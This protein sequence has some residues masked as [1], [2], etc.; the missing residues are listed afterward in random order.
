M[1]LEDKI[2]KIALENAVEHNG[3]AIAH[4][5]LGRVLATEPSMRS[6]IP[7]LHAMIDEIVD[8]VNLLEPDAQRAELEKLGGPE[9]KKR[10]ETKGLPP[11]KNAEKGVV[12]RFAPNPDGAIHLGNARPALLSYAYAQKYNGKF[13][14]RFEDT[15]PKVKTPEKRFYDWIRE[16]VKWLGIKWNTEAIQS[17]RLRIYYDYAERL[18]KMGGAYICTCPVETWR[19]LVKKNWPCSCRSLSLDTQLERWQ[20]MLKYKFKAGQA[21]MRIKTDLAHPNP[22]IRDWPAMRIVDKPVHPLVHKMHVW[23]LYNWSAG[24]DDHLM[25]VTHVLRGQEHSTN[26]TKQRFVYKYFG[27]EYPNVIILGR[28]SLEGLVLS[29][30]VIRA[31]IEKGEYSGWDDPKLGTIRALKRRG[32]QAEALRNMVVEI[33]PTSSD[34]TIALE[35]LAAH[36]RKIV[37]KIANRYFFIAE[38]V[39]IKIDK[40]PVKIAKLKLHPNMPKGWRTLRAGNTL[41]MEKRDI[42]ENHGKEVRLIG[43]Y[44][45]ILNKDKPCKVT[46]IENR[47][48]QKLHWLPDKEHMKVKLI[49]PEREINGLGERTLSKAKIGSVVQFERFSF[50]KIEKK[51]KTGITA[52]FGHK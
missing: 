43:L 47:P 45:I 39:K 36:N 18:I 33:G 16:D 38:P 41:L 49:T 7:E 40:P 26:E 21:V 35:N 3:R 34:S 44:N 31:G 51:S 30:S 29:K 6:R 46:G 15:D 13:V 12:V 24:L 17:Q 14:L 9:Q 48:I 8:D 50:V 42:D 19:E 37:D 5:I 10:E 2:R 23:P 52:V 11:L 1:E 28:F 22:A 25:G 27:W 20:D 4:S 32:W